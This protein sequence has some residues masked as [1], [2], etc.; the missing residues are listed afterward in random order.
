MAA[1]PSV[2][3][4]ETSWGVPVLGGAPAARAGDGSVASPLPGPDWPNSTSRDPCSRPA[5]TA[6]CPLPALLPQV[7]WLFGGGGA[8][9]PWRGACAGAAACLSPVSPAAAPPQPCPDSTCPP[10]SLLAPSSCIK[11]PPSEIACCIR[12]S[13]PT[14]PAQAAAAAESAGMACSSRRSV[15]GKPCHCNLNRLQPF[16]QPLHAGLDTPQPPVDVRAQ[17][18]QPLLQLRLP[19]RWRA[20]V[21]LE[22]SQ[23][24]LQGSKHG[25]VTRTTVS[26]HTAGGTGKPVESVA[27]AAAAG[28]AAGGGANGASNAAKPPAAD[29]CAGDSS[30][31]KSKSSSARPRGAGPP[32]TGEGVHGATGSA[33]TNAGKPPG[34]GIPGDARPGGGLTGGGAGCV[35]PKP[36]PCPSSA[37]SKSPKS[38]SKVPATP[39]AP[40][41]ASTKLLRWGVESKAPPNAPSKPSSPSRKGESLPSLPPPSLPASSNPKA[42]KEAKLSSCTNSRWVPVPVAACGEEPSIPLLL[43][44]ACASTSLRQAMSFSAGRSSHSAST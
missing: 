30:T 6:C 3:R 23:P 24:L 4:P 15:V 2:V 36:L 42:A 7:R 12:V 18:V 19:G 40:G 27:G 26:S 34:D 29:V 31:S 38:A 37:S 25:R 21:V 5:R 43:S 10:W 9:R 28:A 41:K 35:R 44:T 20:R 13:S 8:S 16:V 11:S 22:S 32:G 33:L 39:P 1:P 17:P 14:R